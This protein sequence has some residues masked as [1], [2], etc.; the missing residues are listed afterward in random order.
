[1]AIFYG[2][3]ETGYNFYDTDFGPAPAGSIAVQ[4]D[5]YKKLLIARSCGASLSI[6]GDKVVAVSHDGT[7]I[8]LDTM[9]GSEVYYAP[10]NIKV[11][12]ASALST[13]RTYVYNNYGIL[14]EDTP[15]DWVT[16]LK[17]LMAISNGTDTT[18]T[19][20]PTAPTS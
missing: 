9:S 4:D 18:S 17:S 2:K 10:V 19:A 15:T 1:M 5:L 3:T 11:L 13:A 20:L 6:S 8:D 12:A 7:I 16:Y 14:N